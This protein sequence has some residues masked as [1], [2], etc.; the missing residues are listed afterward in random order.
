MVNM[1]NK[2]KLPGGTQGKGG[3]GGKAVQS[4]FSRLYYILYLHIYIPLEATQ[5][6]SD[7]LAPGPVFFFFAT[8]VIGGG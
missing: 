6:S 5:S 4:K 8:Q 7:F 1:G 3:K 2:L